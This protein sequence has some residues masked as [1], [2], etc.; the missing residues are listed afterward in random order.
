MS[1]QQENGLNRRAFLRNAGM[2]AVLGEVGTRGAFA[3]EME[4]A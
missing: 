3:E 2:T 4:V 1:M